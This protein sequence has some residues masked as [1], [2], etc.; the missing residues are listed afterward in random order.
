MKK[1]LI[2]LLTVALFAS[3]LPAA[4]QEAPLSI[5]ALNFPAYDFARQVAGDRAMITML[6]PPGTDAHSFEPTPRDVIALQQADLVVYNGGHG[7]A[8]VVDLLE[9]MGEQAPASLAMMSVVDTV[10]EE[11]VEGMEDV[12][13]AHSH[14]DYEDDEEHD[15]HD[16]HDHDARDLDEHVWT[17]PDN[18][19]DIAKAIMRLLI[20]LDPAGETVYRANFKAFESA[21]EQLD[22]A[23]EALIKGAKRRTIVLGDRFPMRYFIREYGLSYYAAFPGCA[24]ETEPSARTIAFLMDTIKKEDIPVVFYIEFSSQKAARVIAAETGA[25]P[26]LL[27][28]AHNVTQEELE[29]GI[30]YLDIM[31]QNLINL[32]EALY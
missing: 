17:T 15:D 8:W 4:A 18:A 24:A 20:S 16:G 5:I 27:H 32:K 1:L 11:L 9:S 6:L 19:E 31:N 13:H 12:P 22:E 14:D 28:S 7:E 25:T 21:L 2:A 23:F 3:L 30:T 26:L 29:Q 10:V